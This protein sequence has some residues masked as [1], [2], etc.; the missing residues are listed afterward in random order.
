HGIR[1]ALAES[2]AVKV[3][4]CNIMTQ[5]GET[6]G[7]TASRH[8]QEIQKVSGNILDYVLVNTAKMSEEMRETYRKESSTLVK[9]D[10]KKLEKLGVKVIS[11]DFIK[12]GKSVR[13]DADKIAR[14][15]N[16]LA[17]Q[18]WQQQ[19]KGGFNCLFRRMSKMN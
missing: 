15:V 13:H 2:T 4:V 17:Q 14:I 18:N 5:Q 8:V 11:G 6:N 10:L 16:D 3:Y 19:K 12:E 9:P 1:E 7:Y